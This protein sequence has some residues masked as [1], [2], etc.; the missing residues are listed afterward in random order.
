[1]FINIGKAASSEE[2]R[3]LKDGMVFTN[4]SSHSVQVYD[5][6]RSHQVFTHHSQTSNGGEAERHEHRGTF[7]LFCDLTVLSLPLV[8]T[9]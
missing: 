6:E 4:S 1:M 3:G 5:T 2:G 9:E 8:M 7:L